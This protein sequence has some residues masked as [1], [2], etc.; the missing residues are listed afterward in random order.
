VAQHKYKLNSPKTC[1][2][3]CCGPVFSIAVQLEKVA[4]LKGKSSY[5]LRVVIIFIVFISKLLI[6]HYKQKRLLMILTLYYLHLL[7]QCYFL[8]S[9]F[10]LKSF[11]LFYKRLFLLKTFK[12]IYSYPIK[13]CY[14]PKTYQPEAGMLSFLNWVFYSF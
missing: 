1:I 5:A 11:L 10:L 14:N 2:P 4:P 9:F 3:A 13:C 12:V 6:I 8:Y 7:D